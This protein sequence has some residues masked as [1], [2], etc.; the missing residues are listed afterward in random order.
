MS[1][2]N[3]GGSEENIVESSGLMVLLAWKKYTSSITNATEAAR[4]DEEGYFK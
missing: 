4:S 1:Y 2:E 3:T